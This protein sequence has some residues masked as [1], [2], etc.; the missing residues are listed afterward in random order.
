VTLVTAW[1]EVLQIELQL[2]QVEAELGKA[3]ASLE[4]AVGGQLNEHPPSP[5]SPDSTSTIPPPS[6]SPGPFRGPTGPEGSKIE[7]SPH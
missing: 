5:S 2:A 3:L 6:A 4:R 7:R 1:R